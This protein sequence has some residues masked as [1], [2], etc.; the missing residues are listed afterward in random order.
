MPDKPASIRLKDYDR[1]VFFTG[2]GLSVESGIPTYRGKGGTWE[3]YNWEEVASSRAFAVD[4]DRVL[5][6]HDQRRIDAN[7]CEPNA[8]HRVIAEVQKAKSG[9]I[10]I[11]QNID[12]LHQRAGAREIIELHGSLWRLRC[13]NEGKIVENLE[14]PLKSRK[15]ECGTWWRPDIVWF[16]DPMDEDAIQR[17]V[18]ALEGCDLLVSVGTSGV[19]YPAADLPRIAVAQGAE[20]VE[21]NIDDTPVTPLYKYRLR[22]PATEILTQMWE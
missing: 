14:A 22:G 12:G 13:E 20:S 6:F 4:P 19:V 9:T 10:I 11:T 1:I 5:D 3:K 17:A 8:A 21:V 7:A 16:G 2:A 18:K 15:C